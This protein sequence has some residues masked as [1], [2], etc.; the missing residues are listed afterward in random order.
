MKHLSFT[1]TVGNNDGFVLVTALIIMVVLILFGT[2]ALNTTNVEIQI[3]GNDRV[4][5]EDF[6]NQEGCV[7]N[8]KFQFRTWLTA[9]YLTAGET[10]AFF[11]PAGAVD[12]NANGIADASE[13]WFP[14]LPALAPPALQPV[15]RGSYKIR[16]IEDTGTPIAGWTDAADFG[17]PA[18]HP[19][20]QFPPLAHI[21]KP[22]PI[23]LTELEAA[24]KGYDPKN[25]IIRRYLITSYSPEVDRNTILQQGV[26]KVF[27]KN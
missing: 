24:N 11:P 20:N 19:A 26:F 22:D 23:S 4:A 7:T 25:F 5:K 8:G 21:D 9:A 1:K 27:N 15:L 17:A 18:N 14:P 2:F 12:A 16:N 13:C 3:A 6:T 10:A